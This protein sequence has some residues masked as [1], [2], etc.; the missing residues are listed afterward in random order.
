MI[1][2]IIIIGIVGWLA[3]GGLAA[4]VADQKGYSSGS[5]FACGFLF[6]I[7]GLIAAAGLPAKGGLKDRDSVLSKECPLCAE[8]L[9]LQARVC[10]YC[11]HEFDMKSIISELEALME[12]ADT[13]LSLRVIGIL[14]KQMKHGQKI[15]VDKVCDQLAAIILREAK[16]SEGLEAETLL[17]RLR[18]QTP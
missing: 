8:T 7:F 10:K 4:F 9:K 3:S 18:E 14:V 1:T 5:W 11:G 13:R 15:N 16:T 12:G 17:G 2:T 6:G